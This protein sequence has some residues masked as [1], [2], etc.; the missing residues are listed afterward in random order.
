VDG[1]T[2]V[3][4]AVSLS[5]QIFVAH[6]PLLKMYKPYA[7]MYSPALSF[8]GKLRAT[9]PDFVAFEEVFCPSATATA[10][11]ALCVPRAL[12]TAWRR[13]AASPTP[14]QRRILCAG[15]VPTRCARV[16]A[17]HDRVGVRAPL[18][19]LRPARDRIA[20]PRHVV[21]CGDNAHRCA[22]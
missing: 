5:V 9:R 17:S 20:A 16:G 13:P 8:A 2:A 10:L 12:R 11:C 7:A 15:R 14:P 22:C 3:G 6:A 21:R 19:R 18:Q 1:G 4:A